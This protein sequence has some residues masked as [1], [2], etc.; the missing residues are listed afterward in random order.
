GPLTQ[1]SAWWSDALSDP[2]RNPA[3]HAEVVVSPPPAPAPGPPLEPVE[4]PDRRPGRVVGLVLVTTL[5]STRSTTAARL[6]GGRSAPPARPA[7]PW[8]P[9]SWC[10]PTVT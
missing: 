2:W 5:G 4:P 9:G 7:G 1:E 6:S 8:A 10:P 3:T